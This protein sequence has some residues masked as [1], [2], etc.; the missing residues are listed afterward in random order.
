[1]ILLSFV[2]G[3]GKEDSVKVFRERA[4]TE[5]IN[6]YTLLSPLDKRSVIQKKDYY[7]RMKKDYDNFIKRKGDVR[8]ENNEYMSRL[9]MEKIHAGIRGKDFDDWTYVD[10]EIKF[11][12]MEYAEGILAEKSVFFENKSN[13]SIKIYDSVYYYDQDIYRWV[14]LKDELFTEGKN[15]KEGK[16]R[17]RSIWN[18]DYDVLIDECCEKISLKRKTEEAIR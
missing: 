13:Q 7:E 5:F 6:E 8:I 18:C 11:H 17:K 14:L 1:M 12:D 16:I 3:C 2:I 4:T 10:T 15:E 9:D